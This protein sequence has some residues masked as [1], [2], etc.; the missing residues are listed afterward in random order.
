MRQGQT[1]LWSAC[2]VIIASLGVSGIVASGCGDDD[3][4][5]PGAGGT[6][7][8][9]G[10][11]G[12]AGKGGSGGK[13]GSTMDA[14]TLDVSNAQ[15]RMAVDSGTA[16]A[17]MCF[18]TTCPTQ[19]YQCFNLP[20]CAN[21]MACVRRTM[22]SGLTECASVCMAE[23]AAATPAALALLTNMNF[24]T[25]LTTCAGQC[26]GDGSVPDVR[27]DTTMPPDARPDM[28][29]PPDAP[30]DTTTPPDAPPDTTADT[31]ADAPPD[32][33]ADAPPDTTPPIDVLP[34]TVPDVTPDTTSPD[35]MP[36]TAAD[37]GNDANG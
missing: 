31:T 19:I 32:T 10:S 8:S 17:D 16:C 14:M 21:V 24:Q 7:G 28:T 11:S 25:C 13:G 12:A 5:P 36:D 15:C 37:T 22:C 30:P 6:G 4:T 3:D 18:C 26:L 33:T 34:D 23:V 27:P 1:R 2:V 20:D 35:V 9:A 29:T